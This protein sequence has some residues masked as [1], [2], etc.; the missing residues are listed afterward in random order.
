MRR[1][2]L[3]AA[4]AAVCLAPPLR[5]DAPKKPEP[6]KS[7]AKTYQVPYRFTAFNHVM[8]RAK[9]NGKGPFNFIVDTGAPAL[10]VATE[11]CDKL[12]VKEDKKGWGTFDR[13]EIEGGLV[14]EKA[15]GRV[16]TPFQ[17]KGMNGMGLAGAELH[18]MI[19]YNLIAKYR[20]EFDFS[21]NKMAWTELAFDPPAPEY[22]DGRAKGG[23]SGGLDMLG[24]IM[25]MLG[26]ILGAKATPDVTPRG[27]LGL[28]PEEDNKGVL[29]KSLLDGGAAAAA[30]LKAGD[31][32]LE[33]DGRTVRDLKDLA[34]FLAR[35]KGGERVDV[36]IRR[37]GK[38]MEMVLIVGEGL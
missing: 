24:G 25:Q 19:G 6:K 14:I 7:E 11:V 20:M 36:L 34:K 13:F 3:G 23:A 12:G 28:E 10:F 22:L 32:V 8:I 4:L 15:K 29:V 37:D 9:I 35:R 31:R 26:G 27:F 17:L 21:R 5:A 1:L 38:E 30:G 2:L 16:E 33:F 18:G